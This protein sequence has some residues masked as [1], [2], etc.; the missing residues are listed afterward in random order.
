MEDF[1]FLHSSSKPFLEY[2]VQGR[3]DRILD[4][5]AVRERTYD[6][7]SPDFSV[8]S[9]DWFSLGIAFLSVWNIFWMGCSRELIISYI[10]KYN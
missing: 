8:F 1:F 2:E 3:V 6:W 7:S 5:T 10:G 9:C 4:T